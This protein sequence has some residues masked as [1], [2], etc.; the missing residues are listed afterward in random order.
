MTNEIERLQPEDTF[1]L[2]GFGGTY[3]GDE[4]AFVEHYPI[5]EV[6][7]EPGFVYG[8]TGP[9]W[10]YA[11]IVDSLDHALSA[12][13]STRFLAKS[14]RDLIWKNEGWEL[15]ELVEDFNRREITV[16]PRQT[17]AFSGPIFLANLQVLR[18]EPLKP[19]FETKQGFRVSVTNHSSYQEVWKTYGESA[20]S[21]L[22]EEVA[23]A[24]FGNSSDKMRAAAKIVS[25]NFLIDDHE[26]ILS[27]LVYNI[28]TLAG[29]ERILRFLFIYA[30]RLK[31]KPDE[32]LLQGLSYFIKLKTSSPLS[33]DEQAK[34]NEFIDGVR[35]EL[36]NSS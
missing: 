27:S 14:K 31:I 21:I 4:N 12:S 19:E 24:S 25:I 36:K 8:G 10:S 2:V 18:L 29:R 1:K 30:L 16:K 33:A 7:S 26:R 34:L 13:D 17:L 28:Q 22:N 35:A 3:F 15:T 6:D 11:P 9:E 20:L 5:F 23:K 32:L